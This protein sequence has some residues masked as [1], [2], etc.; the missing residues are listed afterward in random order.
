MP[1]TDTRIIVYDHV[2]NGDQAWLRFTL[3]WTNQRTGDTHTR[4]G[5]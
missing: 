4:A 2:F 3:R 1:Q 5:M